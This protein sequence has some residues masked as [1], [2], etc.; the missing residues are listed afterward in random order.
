[1]KNKK[2]IILSSVAAVIVIGVVL[3]LVLDWPVNKDRSSGDIGKS[4]RFS[5][6]VSTEKLTNMEELLR[7]DTA[8]RQD[9]ADAY[10]VMHTRVL[11]FDALVEMSN[12]AAGNTA[13][14]ADLLKEMNAM[15]STV[16]N[17][18]AQLG[19]AGNDL[20]AVLS[21]KE[22]PDLEQDVINAS[23]AYTTL[24]KKN[25]LADRFIE[26]ADNYLKKNKASDE[27]KLVRDGWMEY[28]QMT[29]ALEGDT[30]AAKRLEEL[31]Y[32]LTEEQTLA[33][34]RNND[35]LGIRITNTP[36]LGARITNT[37]VLDVR[38]PLF[39]RMRDPAFHNSDDVL[40]SRRKIE[41]Y[42]EIE[43]KNNPN[44]NLIAINDVIIA[45]AQ[46]LKI[47]VIQS[48]K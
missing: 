25:Q 14:F 2:V 7:T 47:I 5:Q 30:K 43:I 13:E 48:P 28:Q 39:L 29:A 1:M 24:Q 19:K 37:D 20:E 26:T 32:Q 6:K 35:E 33:F 23:L 42:R 17:A 34:I 45:T 11:Q 44:V 46:G 38:A 18:S 27:L 15:R 41:K 4:V 40:G 16:T 9:I 10:V 3:S 21:G 8:Y 22:C 12:K 31:G 36:D